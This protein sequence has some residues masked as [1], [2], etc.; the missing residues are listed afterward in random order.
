MQP[1]DLAFM[2]PLKTYY[3]QEIENWLRNN[4]G[5]VVTSYQVCELL[6]RA[7]VRCATAEIAI[8]GFRKSATNLP[9][10]EQQ[11]QVTPPRH[12]AIHHQAEGDRIPATNLPD[13]EQQKQVTPPR[14]VTHQ[15]CINTIKCV[16]DSS[17]KNNNVEAVSE[18]QVEKNQTKKKTRKRVRNEKSGKRNEKK[19]KVNCGEGYISEGKRNI[20]AKAVKPP[21]KMCR[22]KCVA[23]FTPN[24]RKT[25]HINY[26][27]RGD[28][29][30]HR[31]YVAGHMEVLKAKYSR[32]TERS[33]R[34][35]NISYFLT[36]NGGI[37][38]RVCK[39]FFMNT[40]DIG[41]KFIRTT[42]AKARD[43][44]AMIARDRR[45]NYN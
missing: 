5:R 30:L 16:K 23:S 15:R 12:F 9:D 38:K 14:H 36:I 26:W 21:C 4:P 31:Q 43:T 2:G 22:F 33:N 11:K 6:G 45:G 40:L 28:N 39:K 35:A 32:M 13:A 3:S 10:A 42:W 18:E 17:E 34:R 8:N 37:K 41:D 1:L 25:I 19:R 20:A 24:E 44:N 7:Y 29:A 27:N